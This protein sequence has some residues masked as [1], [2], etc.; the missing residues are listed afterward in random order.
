MCAILENFQTPEGVNIPE[1]LRKYLPGAPDFL[2]FTK[3]V[4]KEKV[5]NNKGKVDKTAGAKPKVAAAAN[6]AADAVGKVREKL[7]NAVV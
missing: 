6:T 7:K 1:P 3:E 2:P 5:A 4:P